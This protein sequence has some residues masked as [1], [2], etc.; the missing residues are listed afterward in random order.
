MEGWW[1]RGRGWGRDWGRRRVRVRD[2]DRVRVRVRVSFRARGMSMGTMCIELWAMR[3]V[4]ALPPAF[5]M[6]VTEA[7]SHIL[8]AGG[9]S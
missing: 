2:R 3:S 5:A 7:V 1:V 8:G 6:A 9:G 4:L